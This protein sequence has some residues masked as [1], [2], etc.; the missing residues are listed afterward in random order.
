[1]LVTVAAPGADPEGETGS[2]VALVLDS[3]EAKE[4]Q[5]FPAPD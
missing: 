1:M 3:G 2:A 4:C 5:N